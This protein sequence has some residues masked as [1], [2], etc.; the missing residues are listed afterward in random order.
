VFCVFTPALELLGFTLFEISLMSPPGG[1]FYQ[2]LNQSTV[3]R[4]HSLQAKANPNRIA[5]LRI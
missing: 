5:F 4:H 1:L 3:R 2:V